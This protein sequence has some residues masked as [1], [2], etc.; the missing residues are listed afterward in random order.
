M[1]IDIQ[2]KPKR[3]VGQSHFLPLVVQ[4]LGKKIENFGK[5]RAD[6]GWVAKIMIMPRMGNGDD[7][8]RVGCTNTV[9]LLHDSQE[10]LWISAQVFKNI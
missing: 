6:M 10:H 7:D 4:S 9:Q 8:M 2:I 3:R 5:N 1:K